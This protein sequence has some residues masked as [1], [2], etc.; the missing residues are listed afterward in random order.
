M[1]Y[2]GIIGNMTASGPVCVSYSGAAQT[3]MWELFTGGSTFFSGG[4]NFLNSNHKNV[5]FVCAM[6]EAEI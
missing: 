1:Y 3:M 2:T 6:E 5:I 4:T